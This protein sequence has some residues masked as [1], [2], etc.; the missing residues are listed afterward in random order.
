[1]FDEFD[2]FENAAIPIINRYNGRLLC[3]IRTS[4]EVFIESAIDQPYEIH[5]VEF[6][7]Q[8]DFEN[9]MKDETRK[10]FLHLKTKSIQSSILYKGERL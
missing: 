1:V 7:S 2:E 4:A 3:R 5:I 8:Q 9:F 6:N 10:Q